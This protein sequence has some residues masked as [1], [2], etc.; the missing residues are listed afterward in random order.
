MKKTIFA[1]LALAGAMVHSAESKPQ[2]IIISPPA[3]TNV[4]ETYVDYRKT[5]HPDYDFLIKN[6]DE[7]YAA[8]PEATNKTTFAYAKWWPD[9]A[10]AIH[11]YLEDVAVKGETVVILGA[12]P[13]IVNTECDITKEVPVRYAVNNSN[14]G[15]D[16][17]RTMWVPTDLYYACLDKNE[18]AEVWDSQSDGFYCG[19]GERGTF[20]EWK[21][22]TTGMDWE[23]D[24]VVM[25][26]PL[27]ESFTVNGVTKTAAEIMSAYVEKLKKGE[28]DDF[29]GRYR[30][31]LVG[32]KKAVGNS[33]AYYYDYKVYS[34]LEEHEFFDGQLNMFDSGHPRA[35][36]NT[37]FAG[38]WMG[39]N[40]FA[41][42]RGVE[43]LIVAAGDLLKSESVVSAYEA[44]LANGGE[45]YYV[46]GHGHQP[47][48][49]DGLYTTTNVWAWTSL[50]KFC[51]A[52]SPCLTGKIDAA[53]ADG[54]SVRCVA[55]A[56]VFAPDGGFLVSFNNMR[57]GIMYNTQPNYPDYAGR[58]AG[59]DRSRASP[60]LDLAVCRYIHGY[61]DN[62]EYNAGEALLKARQSCK[63]MSDGDHE[64]F[65]LMELT[66]YGDPFVKLTPQ[67]DTTWTGGTA[68]SFTTSRRIFA[69]ASEANAGYNLSGDF[70][71]S[72]L[73]LEGPESGAF[74]LAGGKFRAMNLVSVT[75][76][77]T[78]SWASQ[79]G[80]AH[81]GIE[82]VGDAGRLVLPGGEKRYFGTNFVNV[83]GIDVTGG[84]VTLDF[85]AKEIDTDL[86]FISTDSYYTNTLRSSLVN[87]SSGLSAE[88]TIAVANGALELESSGLLK[89]QTGAATGVAATNATLLVRVSPTWDAALLQRP[90]ELNA[91]KFV[92]DYDYVTFGNGS[93]PFVIHASGG[94]SAFEITD[95]ALEARYWTAD[96]S[97]AGNVEFIVDNGATMV[98]TL[99]RSSAVTVSADLSTSGNLVFITSDDV[100]NAALTTPK[101][102]CYKADGASDAP[103]YKNI[104]FRDANGT[105]LSTTGLHTYVDGAMVYLGEGDPEDPVDTNVVVAEGETLA[106]TSAEAYDSLTVYGTVTV[107]ADG[108]ISTA[109]LSGTGRI[110]YT[111]KLPD[112]LGWT[113]ENW[114]GTVAVK[115]MTGDGSA[116]PFATYGSS[117]SAVELDGVTGYKAPAGTISV[118]VVIGENGVVFVSGSSFTATTIWENLSG[119]GHFTVNKQTHLVHDAMNFTGD[120]SVNEAYIGFGTTNRWTGQSAFIAENRF[121]KKVYVEE[122]A[123]VSVRP[124][125]VWNA[126][127][128][129]VVNGPVNVI[130]SGTLTDGTVLITNTLKRVAMDTVQPVTI[131]GTAKDGYALVLNDGVNALLLSVASTGYPVTNGDDVNATITVDDAWLTEHVG[132]TDYAAVTNKLNSVGANGAL[133]WESYVAG[134]NPTNGTIK[135]TS[136]TYDAST[137]KYT[138]VSDWDSTA[139]P[140][141]CGLTPSAVLQASDYL[142][143]SSVKEIE[144]NEGGSF[145]VVPEA[146]DARKFYRLRLKF[147]Q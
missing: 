72:E 56:G 21:V 118:P 104:S 115:S 145:T 59:I 33:L 13:G 119:A 98:S 35:T 79:G 3:F 81:N 28:K 87:S 58:N 48:L 106:V 49:D 93:D 102:L 46:Y 24:I 29:Q 103:F 120:I 70:S 61:F 92:V 47:G 54:T 36:L 130:A 143:F 39:Q 5:T 52:G 83:A 31:Q 117:A 107:S 77:T 131:N 111:G 42:T 76:A 110:E 45:G 109:N 43:S 40:V 62:T 127:S 38:R 116:F 99:D 32:G 78:L 74:T 147:A 121:A 7:I 84:N 15:T 123:K 10:L 140:S 89:A 25:R 57:N 26:M 75:N 137:G 95:N 71:A 6:T 124:G 144:A 23:A 18:G 68:D 112:S 53:P 11:H 55:Q 66:G 2:V 136:F 105:K 9:Y 27:A 133:Y 64:S 41:G 88:K 37:E 22:D 100:L 63:D 82:F 94:E 14:A 113:G 135:V 51:F 96:V 85:S 44:E 128:M 132:L 73:R 129:V 139:A 114:T 60:R 141:G 8:Y 134:L 91:S 4:W 108:S 97:F 20:S 17:V 50:Y 16:D 30:Y 69:S 1:A 19:A 12:Q 138:V 80:A 90:V 65:A 126:A 101:L 125:S 34:Y 67:S 142:S 86:N 122:D 146:A